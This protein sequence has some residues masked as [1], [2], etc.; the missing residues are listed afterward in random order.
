MQMNK[1]KFIV[2]CFVQTFL[3]IFFFFCLG[4]PPPTLVWIQD[5]KVVEDSFNSDPRGQ[6]RNLLH[7]ENINRDYL[8]V[9]F[10]CRASNNN[11]TGSLDTSVKINIT[12]KYCFTVQN[13]I[14]NHHSSCL[15]S[16]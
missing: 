5:G 15:I 8:D 3:I 10:T 11:I 16:K 4:R 7:L 14:L 1:C 2:C 12:R 9:T 6:I 13:L